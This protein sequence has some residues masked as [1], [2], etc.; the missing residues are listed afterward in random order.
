MEHV[1]WADWT[2]AVF[3]ILLVVVTA[4]LWRATRDLV[5]SAERS[6]ERQLRAYVSLLDI[7]LRDSN[8]TYE[9]LL[10]KGVAHAVLEFQNEPTV[11]I[12]I[13]NYGK[14]PAYHVRSVV[15]M[16]IEPIANEAAVVASPFQPGSN[17]SIGPGH[18]FTLSQRFMRSLTSEEM[19]RIN[20]GER[21]I[22]AVGRIEYETAFRQRCFTNF[23]LQYH[24]LYPPAKGSGFLY[25]PDG[26]E[27]EVTST[28][29]SR[30]GWWSRLRRRVSF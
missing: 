10:R 16:Q 19:W 4:A 21:S 1:G 6:S 29:P 20:N 5:S 17:S 28:P 11:R 25:C 24:G 18:T 23:K 2:I 8:Q 22:Y 3:T 14:T 27:N 9:R 26:N 15:H 7:K 30:V 13:K 12:R